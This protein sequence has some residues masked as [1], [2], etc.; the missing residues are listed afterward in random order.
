MKVCER[1]NNFYTT[2]FNTSICFDCWD[3]LSEFTKW[4]IIR[5]A[6]KEKKVIILNEK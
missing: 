1:C 6:Q 4:F 5:K 2:V 3:E